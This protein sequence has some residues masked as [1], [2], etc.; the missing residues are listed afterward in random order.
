MRLAA[1]AVALAACGGAAAKPNDPHHKGRGSIEDAALPFHILGVG[2][3]E[4]AP[5]DF[6]SV[7]DGARAICIA[8]HHPNPHHHWVQ[9]T[10]YRQLLARGGSP[11]LGMEMFQ[12]PFQGVLD[13]FAAGRI[14]EATLLERSGWEER[15]GYDWALYQPTVAAAVARGAPLLALN[16]PK[17][18][19]KKVARQGLTSLSPDEKS[20]LP[21]LHLDDEGHRAFFRAATQG[22]GEGMPADGEPGFENFYAAQVVWDETMADGTARWLAGA[23]DKAQVVILAGTGH[24]QA[25]GIPLRL[26]RRG[27]SPV[28]SVAPVVDDGEGAV[29]DALAARENDYLIVL[30]ARAPR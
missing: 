14:D 9:L 12:R 4:I 30:E 24:C 2:G 15:W 13:D 25:T 21:E 29:A 26:A 5:G 6:A 19:V 20:Q 3:S 10:L 7:L 8:E 28:V 17:E 11:A 16:A 18:I 27:I 1:F 22:H 23:G